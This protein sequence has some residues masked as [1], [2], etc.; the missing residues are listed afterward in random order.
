MR[1]ISITVTHICHLTALVSESEFCDA[2]H[3]IVLVVESAVCASANGFFGRAVA[4]SRQCR[5]LNAAPTRKRVALI[6]SMH[7]A[8]TCMRLWQSERIAPARLE[9]CA[10][11][12][13]DS[14][15]SLQDALF[16]LLSKHNS[17]GGISEGFSPFERLTATRIRTL[18]YRYVERLNLLLKRR[19]NR[20]IVVAVKACLP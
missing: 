17:G 12:S 6:A 1:A 9:P 8:C 19:S 10:A 20:L 14:A 3:R 13:K 2:L 7:V 18:R 4:R 15:A 11:P 16:P 5:R